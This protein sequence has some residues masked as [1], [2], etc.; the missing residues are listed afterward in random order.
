MDNA[1]SQGT[2][3]RDGILNAHPLQ[4]LHGRDIQGP[5]QRFSGG[6]QSLEFPVEIVRVLDAE[7]EVF[8]QKG[9]SGVQALP[10]H[11][12]GIDKRF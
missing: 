4:H 3:K 6:N 8:I 7:I 2:Q 11:G 1:E 12:I 5:A 9:F 10:L